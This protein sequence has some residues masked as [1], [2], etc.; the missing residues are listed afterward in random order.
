[1]TVRND[2]LWNRYQILPASEDGFLIIELE[3][4]DAQY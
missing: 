2:D 1:M 3:F 4:E